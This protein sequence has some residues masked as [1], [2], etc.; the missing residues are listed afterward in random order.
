VE[1]HDK[2]LKKTTGHVLPHFQIRSG[3]TASKQA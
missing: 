1:G 3:A 2:N